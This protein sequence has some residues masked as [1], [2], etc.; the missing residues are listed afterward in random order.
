MPRGMKAMIKKCMQ[1]TNKKCGNFRDGTQSF[2]T[3]QDRRSFKNYCAAY[4]NGIE[5]HPDNC[6]AF[7]S[8]E[9]DALLR[10]IENP[11]CF[12]FGKGCGT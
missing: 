5:L 7:I 1:C 10:A 11:N 9:K 12:R 2:E 8:K 3:A 6:E 4:K